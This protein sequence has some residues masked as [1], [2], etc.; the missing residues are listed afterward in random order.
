MRIDPSAFFVYVALAQMKPNSKLLLFL[1]A[2]YQT[3]KYY[4]NSKKKYSSK[5]PEELNDLVDV[6]T[7]LCN[8]LRTFVPRECTRNYRKDHNQ[9]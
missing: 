2:S 4:R 1:Y 3:P 7:F 9:Y 8:Y 5:T 6:E